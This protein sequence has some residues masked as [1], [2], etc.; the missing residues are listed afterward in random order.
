MWAVGTIF[1]EISHKRPLFRGDSEIDQI[2]KIFRILGSP[3]EETW[4]SFSDLPQMKASF[5][6]WNVLNSNNLRQ[7]SSNLDHQALDLLIQMLQL[8]PSKRISA[9]AAL[10]HPYFQSL[11]H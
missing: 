7:L 8:E 2:F 11:Y 5:P 1:F 3:T 6:R 4:Q 9:K 10:C